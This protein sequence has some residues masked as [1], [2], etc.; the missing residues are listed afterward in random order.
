MNFSEQLDTLENQQVWV[1]AIIAQNQLPY[2]YWLAVF[3]G[4]ATKLFTTRLKT[5]ITFE[6]IWVK[7]IFFPVKFTANRCKKVFHVL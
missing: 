4:P 3:N 5:N 1:Y 6:S 7:G 2:R